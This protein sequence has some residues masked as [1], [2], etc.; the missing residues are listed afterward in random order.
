MRRKRSS[1]YDQRRNV[2]FTT[3]YSIIDDYV[4]PC[5]YCGDPATTLDHYPPISSVPKYGVLLPACHECNAFARDLY[6]NNF[7]KRAEH[8][9]TRISQKHANALRM[10]RWQADELDEI[11]G[12][13]RK[14]VEIW[15]GR[16][17]ATHV[18]L[19]WDAVTYLRH[20]VATR[21]F[22]VQGAESE[23]IRGIVGSLLGIFPARIDPSSAD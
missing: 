4:T 9:K 21:S 8:V 23:H 7:V 17:R 11:S 10:P 18:R 12:H 22:V 16:R 1:R 15:Q 5:V 19:A 2:R 3:W 14:D 20:I 6:F 13:M